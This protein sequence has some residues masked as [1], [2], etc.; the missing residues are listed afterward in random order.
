MINLSISNINPTNICR[1]EFPAGLLL[2]STSKTVMEVLLPN[3]K[4]KN[5]LVFSD[6][7]NVGKLIHLRKSA[8]PDNMFF[9]LLFRG[10]IPVAEI[11]RWVTTVKAIKWPKKKY[12]NRQWESREEYFSLAFN[13]NLIDTSFTEDQYLAQEFLL[14]AFWDWDHIGGDLEL[15]NVMQ[16]W[17]STKHYF[18]DF[19]VN[20]G[21]LDV[22]PPPVMDFPY[23]GY[24]LYR[25]NVLLEFS[26]LIQSLYDQYL[27][28][29]WEHLFMAIYEKSKMPIND[30]QKI[31]NAFYKQLNRL[32]Q[33]FIIQYESN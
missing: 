30:F 14:T 4:H 23:E 22:F 11:M 26:K 10:I 27:W 5:N 13:P 25:E 19:I 32:F 15:T 8:G 9:S 29:E 18:Y 20:M 33:I 28:Q 7:D 3:Q 24:E 12:R 17:D 6:P 31:K 16:N 2:A 1:L 21:N